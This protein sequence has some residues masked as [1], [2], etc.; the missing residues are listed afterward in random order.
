MT[1]SSTIEIETSKP[2]V[3]RLSHSFSMKTSFTGYVGVSL[4]TL[5]LIIDLATCEIAMFLIQ[6]WRLSARAT[7]IPGRSASNA[8]ARVIANGQGNYRIEGGPI[9]VSRA[10]RARG[11]VPRMWFTSSGTFSGGRRRRFAMATST[12]RTAAGF[13]DTRCSTKT[14]AL[15]ASTP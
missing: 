3:Y 15:W 13:S 6:K 8:K 1:P 12:S 9:A 4:L 10:A 2:S 14:S 7:T 11:N 5:L